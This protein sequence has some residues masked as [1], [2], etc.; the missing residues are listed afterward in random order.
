M[1]N[2]IIKFRGKS[3][4]NGEWVYG[5]LNQIFVPEGSTEDCPSIYDKFDGTFFVHPNSVGQFTGIVDKDN[6]QI[7]EGDIVRSEVAACNFA[8]GASGTVIFQ[9]VVAFDEDR[10]GFSPFVEGN[11]YEW[12]VVGNIHDRVLTYKG[13]HYKP[14]SV[15]YNEA[16]GNC[17]K[18]ALK[19]S[20]CH[21]GFNAN[22]CEV[23]DYLQGND[24]EVFVLQEIPEPQ[25][26]K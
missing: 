25:N 20:N 18:C 26:T 16:T 3:I 11:Y 6:E 2:R 19:N 10:A 23:F 4:D 12:E 17:S 1:E 14:I 7:Y 9:Y 24:N 22:V 13:K 5:D 8:D 15:P 21:L